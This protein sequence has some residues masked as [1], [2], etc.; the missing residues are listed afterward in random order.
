[1]RSP[2]EYRDPVHPHE[3]GP[4]EDALP[5][6]TRGRV[7]AWLHERLERVPRT[8]VQGGTVVAVL[9]LGAVHFAFAPELPFTLFYLAPIAVAAWYAE[10][11][12]YL[13]ATVAAAGW[14]VGTFH[15]LVE[16]TGTTLVV[17]SGAMYLG[18]FLA[19]AALTLRLR[20]A[21][22]LY[23]SSAERDSLTG[24]LNHGAFRRK[25]EY[26][27]DRAL[28]YGRIFTVAYVDLDRFK[29]VNDNRGHAE[30][31]AVLKRLAVVL[32]D[33]TR[34]TDAAARVG[35]DEFALLLPET[36][37]ARAEKALGMLQR[38]I[39]DAMEEG[40][41]PTSA[42]I[43]A[44]TFEAPVDSADEALGLADRFMYEVKGE[45]GDAVHHVLWTGE[46]ADH[47]VPGPADRRPDRG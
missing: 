40:G 27:I 39:R 19:V 9:V 18:L 44:V 22:A 16:P 2:D 26:E 11:W 34:A 29:E 24:L 13:I 23:R 37:Y 3:P 33:S 35:G 43:G 14:T 42:S 1:M 28:R 7:I 32:E 25:V 10:G 45:G 12:T 6:R 8:R 15:G 46:D 5:E 41:W 38:R 36:P 4:G 31:D 30:G 21:M 17:W 47:P 20:H